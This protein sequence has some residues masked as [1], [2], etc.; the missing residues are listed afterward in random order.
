MKFIC[1]IF[2]GMGITFRDESNEP[3]FNMIDYSDATVITPNQPSER[4]VKSLISYSTCCSTI[5]VQAI[6]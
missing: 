1:K 6:S 5:V 3:S 2:S 4:T